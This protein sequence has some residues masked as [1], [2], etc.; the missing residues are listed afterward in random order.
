[1]K[2]MIEDKD[3]TYTVYKKYQKFYQKFYM[4]QLKV[5]DMKNIQSFLQETEEKIDL[6]YSYQ[7]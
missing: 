1:M 4:Q 3:V 2:T 6:I 7:E 5:E